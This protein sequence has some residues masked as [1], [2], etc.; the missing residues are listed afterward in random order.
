M[1]NEHTIESVFDGN[2]KVYID[3]NLFKLTELAVDKIKVLILNNE[4]L[5]GRSVKSK[6]NES[7]T[8]IEDEDLFPGE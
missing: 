2:I 5:I 7:L 3:K 4:E 6:I 8:W 1:Y